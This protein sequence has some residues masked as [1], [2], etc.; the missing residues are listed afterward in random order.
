MVIC[1]SLLYAEI[2]DAFGFLFGGQPK[3]ITI[4]GIA[5][6]AIGFVLEVV[7]MILHMTNALSIANSILVSTIIYELSE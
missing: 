2:K 1:A 6:G 7:T 5:A 3:E 4:Y